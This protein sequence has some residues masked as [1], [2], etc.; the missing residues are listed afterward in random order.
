MARVK[1]V[2]NTESQWNVF[3][4]IRSVGNRDTNKSVLRSY[5]LRVLLT[6]FGK[7]TYSLGLH[8]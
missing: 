2:N 3:V 4:R 1:D 6:L 7:M 5:I 8:C